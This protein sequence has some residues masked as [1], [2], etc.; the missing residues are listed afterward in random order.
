M[1]P[2]AP[3]WRGR[4]ARVGRLARK[5]LNESLRDRRTVLTL[6][7]MPLLLYPLLAIAFQHMLL[8]AQVEKMPA[9]YRVGVVS[10]E[11]GD[12]LLD[13]WRSGARVVAMRNARRG[14][15]VAPPEGLRMPAPPPPSPQVRLVP[16]AT[17]QELGVAALD[18]ALR[19]A[20]IDVAIRAPPSGPLRPDPR[21][22]L[23]V[24][25]EVRYRE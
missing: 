16:L 3:S 25:V 21:Q 2:S 6:I 17:L 15:T 12:T 8:S 11:E 24:G 5:E 13:Y 23:A 10:Q 19:R 7:L 1:T 20:L 18:E 4:L 9:A 14:G 22:P